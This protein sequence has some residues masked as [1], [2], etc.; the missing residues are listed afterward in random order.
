MTCKECEG[1]GVVGG[2]RSCGAVDYGSTT[3]LNVKSSTKLP[4]AEVPEWYKHHAW[5]PVM[6]G[7]SSDSIATRKVIDVLNSLVQHSSSGILPTNSYMV[8]LPKEHGKRHALFTMILN[9]QS[10]GIHVAPVADIVSFNLMSSRN[11]YEDQELMLSYLRA[12]MTFVYGTEFMTRKLSASIFNNLVSSRALY[13]KPTVFF[14]GHSYDELS[15]WSDSVT[16]TRKANL[17]EI[18][19]LSNPY[20]LDGVVRRHKK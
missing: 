11:R 9:Y 8:L 15:E 7:K 20:I 1:R 5:D 16:L 2:C 12:D 6:A 18:D 17:D 3:E 4:Q 10:K 14:G 13:G 19:H